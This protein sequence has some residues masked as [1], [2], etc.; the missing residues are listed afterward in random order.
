MIWER[1]SYREAVE[2]AGAELA[3]AEEA[4]EVKRPK[5]DLTPERTA[6]R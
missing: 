6:T 4:P 2:A 3:V 5:A 1:R